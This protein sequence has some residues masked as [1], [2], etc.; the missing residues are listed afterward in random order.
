MSEV[1][2]EAILLRKAVSELPAK[3]KRVY[4]S[5]SADARPGIQEQ[6]V[7]AVCNLVGGITDIEVG[8]QVLFA[9]LTEGMVLKTASPSGPEWVLH[10]LKWIVERGSHPK[11]ITD[12]YSL[13]LFKAA[14]GTAMRKY[15]EDINRVPAYTGSDMWWDILPEPADA[16]SGNPAVPAQPHLPPAPAP[17]PT[18]ATAS[19]T[20]LFDSLLPTR[21][22]APKSG[23]SQGEDKGP[24]AGPDVPDKSNPAPSGRGGKRRELADI[25]SED[26][27]APRP[28]RN[29]ARGVIKSTVVV[30][31]EDEDQDELEATPA[32]KKRTKAASKQKPKPKP[33]VTKANVNAKAKPAAGDGDDADVADLGSDADADGDTDEEVKAAKRTRGA[34]RKGKEKEVVPEEMEVDGDVYEPPK[35]KRSA[36]GKRKAV[37][38]SDDEV[39]VVAPPKKVGRTKTPA[40]KPPRHRAVRDASW[41]SVKGMRFAAE[42]DVYKALEAASPATPVDDFT[43]F[44]TPEM[45]GLKRENL[46]QYKEPCEECW[47]LK[48]RCIVRPLTSTKKGWTCLHCYNKQRGCSAKIAGRAPEIGRDIEFLTPE[49]HNGVLPQLL[50]PDAT[51]RVAMLEKLLAEKKLKAWP[52]YIDEAGTITNPDFALK[53]TSGEA[54]SQFAKVPLT[55]PDDASYRLVYPGINM[56]NV[57]VIKGEIPDAVLPPPAPAS[58]EV[59]DVDAPATSGGPGPRTRSKSN[60]GRDKAPLALV[61]TAGPSNPTVPTAPTMPAVPSRPVVGAAGVEFQ[62]ADRAGIVDTL[63]EITRSLDRLHE[64][65]GAIEFVLG[66]DEPIFNVK[67]P[68]QA[69][70]GRPQKPVRYGLSLDGVRRARVPTPSE[71]E[72]DA[73]DPEDEQNGEEKMQEDGHATNEDAP[74]QDDFDKDGPPRPDTAPEQPEPSSSGTSG[75]TRAPLPLGS[76]SAPAP[77]KDAP[78]IKPSGALVAD[79]T[80][81][82]PAAAPV[83]DPQ[84]AAQTP[85]PARPHEALPPAEPSATKETATTSPEHASATPATPVA[86]SGPTATATAPT[87]P[88]DALGK[89]SA[90]NASPSAPLALPPTQSAPSPAESDLPMGSDDEDLRRS[91][92]PAADASPAK[93]KRV[94]LQLPEKADTGNTNAASGPSGQVPTHEAFDGELSE[95]DSGDED[96][97][98]DKDDAPSTTV[99]EQKSQ[100]P[101]EKSVTPPATASEAIVTPE[102][103]VEEAE[104]VPEPSPKKRGTRSMPSGPPLATRRSKKADQPEPAPSQA[105]ASGPSRKRKLP[106]PEEEDEEEEEEPVKKKATKAAKA[107]AKKPQAPKPR[108]KKK[109]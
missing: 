76:A 37:Q 2:F 35:T 109:N 30:D 13:S 3:L 36:K 16:V 1:S 15:Q 24:D 26:E 51:V 40:V 33:K 69:L 43:L 61:P 67:H 85:T 49:G 100:S 66:I 7:V 25:T 65:L 9:L 89:P 74:M 45:H 81:Q 12:A 79:A 95:L 53:L 70:G 71:D 73:E 93:G 14:T 106:L 59:I 88:K 62:F 58:A 77:G 75:P 92:D 64:R 47:R 10:M 38:E 101:V 44:Q 78:A 29:R 105:A 87:S 97:I 27:D 4:S 107:V 52:W 28:K 83:P 41:W 20:A 57:Q 6:R 103:A 42:R 55:W 72:D 46:A 80:P 96:D 11:D 102:P 50:P 104:E 86:G 84:P 32:P 22:A 17:A 90:A 48:S 108:N 5:Y 82:L 8:Q 63:D 19:T 98:V 91:R 68:R 39:A 23:T 54:A 94:R 60:A 56:S 34:S 99:A 18:Q 21:E 31:S